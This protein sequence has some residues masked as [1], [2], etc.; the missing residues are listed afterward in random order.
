[1]RPIS[2]TDKM[3]LRADALPN[4]PQTFW[5]K[6]NSPALSSGWRASST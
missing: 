5:K 6:R 2:K 1:M 3:A 4:R